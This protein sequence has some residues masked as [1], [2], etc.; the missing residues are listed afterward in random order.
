[1]TMQRSM[2]VSSASQLE[3][4]R[5]SDTLSRLLEEL[6]KPGAQ[7]RRVEGDRPLADY[8]ESEARDLAPDAFGRLLNDLYFRLQALLSR[9]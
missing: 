5:M 9:Q 3:S 6:C 4:T 2:R 1:M 7:E 8:V